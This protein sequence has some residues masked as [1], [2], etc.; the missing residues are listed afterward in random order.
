MDRLNMKQIPSIS[1]LN[2]HQE[3][4]KKY[5]IARV[6]KSGFPRMIFLKK[7]G[8][9]ISKKIDVAFQFRF[10]LNNQ[11]ILSSLNVKSISVVKSILSLINIR[12]NDLQSLKQQNSV[13]NLS[14]GISKF[15]TV[16]KIPRNLHTA[17]G[18]FPLE[19]IYKDKIYLFYFLKIPIHS[20]GSINKEVIKRRYSSLT[21]NQALNQQI[22]RFFVPKNTIPTYEIISLAC[23]EESGRVSTE[24]LLERKISNFSF[25]KPSFLKYQ[26]GK[27]KSNGISKILLNT[28]HSFNYQT[29]QIIPLKS[30]I[31]DFKRISW[32]FNFA[33]GFFSSENNQ[34]NCIFRASSLN[35]FYLKSGNKK[36]ERKKLLKQSL[37]IDILF[38][39]QTNQKISSNSEVLNHGVIS[40]TDNVSSE[41]LS[42][43]RTYQSRTTLFPLLKSL[44]FQNKIKNSVPEKELKTLLHV[45]TFLDK[46]KTNKLSSNEIGVNTRIISKTYK[47]VTGI[48]PAET[49]HEKRIPNA[50]LIKFL[51][52][53]SGKKKAELNKRVK[54]LIALNTGLFQQLTKIFNSNKIVSSSQ[55]NSQTFNVLSDFFPPSAGIPKNKISRI[56]FLKSL[57]FRAGNIKTES[58][59]IHNILLN[60]N[61]AFNRQIKK[62]TPSENLMEKPQV[63]QVVC[64]VL[65]GS[66]LTKIIPT[67]R[68]SIVSFLKSLVFNTGDK[69]TELSKILNPLLIVDNF[70]NPKKNQIVSQTYNKESR[71]FTVESIPNNKISISSF[72]KSLVFRI[73]SIKTESDKVYTKLSQVNNAFNLQEIQLFSSSKIGLNLHAIPCI[74]KA[75]SGL[76]P[77]K[78]VS[79]G[80]ISTI[81]FPAVLSTKSSFFRSGNGKNEV[82]YLR[83]YTKFLNSLILSLRIN[84]KMLNATESVISFN[85]DNMH[86]KRSKFPS[87]LLQNK[88]FFNNVKNNR[89]RLIFTD[90]DQTIGNKDLAMYEYYG[91]GYDNSNFARKKHTYRIENED[92]RFLN[93]NHIEQEIEL[94]KR[95]VIQTKESLLQKSTSTLGEADIKRYL[96]IN[97]ISDQV[98][99]NIARRI[100]IEREMR[101]T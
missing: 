78:I 32:V 5:Q 64:R 51:A 24:D 81:S 86:K 39:R 12:K 8:Q 36:V 46:K 50:F 87:V 25:P 92:L 54:S 75:L 96:D 47:I 27:N 1:F 56:S 62:I 18:L 70:L 80:R 41:I 20:T 45:N 19:N 49:I 90:S 60:L 100:R 61:R 53:N 72:F 79:A 74:N 38:N 31:V 7:S 94:I 82:S 4:I 33:S 97:R 22:N 2:F 29:N 69:K 59:K 57:V 42:T 13:W 91:V 34:N 52:F 48:F 85:K 16:L 101:G 15:L 77:I 11:I 93:S 37:I 3:I 88:L 6:K 28:D 71:I 67:N 30:K 63:A 10:H 21:L 99:Q 26:N 66:M 14:N 17:Q 58:N 40:Q 98:Y 76:S 23:Q 73:R 44:I 35:I 68:I 83:N 95:I 65:S 55:V 89:N 9:N 84:H 43:D